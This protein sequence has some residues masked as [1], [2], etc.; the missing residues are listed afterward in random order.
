MEDY[1][2]ARNAVTRHC[3]QWRAIQTTT[4]DCFAGM[5]FIPFARNGGFFHGYLSRA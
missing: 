1:V 5:F 3:K 2:I 4:L